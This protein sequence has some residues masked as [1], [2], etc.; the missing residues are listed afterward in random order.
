MNC[1]AN[2]STWWGGGSGWTSGGGGGWGGTK[3]GP[4]K[5]RCGDG[6]LQSRHGEECDDGN[7]KDDDGCSD[8]CRLE[9]WTEDD[10]DTTEDKFESGIIKAI[11]KLKDAC[12]Y[13]DLVYENIFFRDVYWSPYRSAISVLKSAC[14]INGYGYGKRS[15]A[16]FHADAAVGIGE[17]IKVVSK[18]YALEEGVMFDETETHLGRLPYADMKANARYTTYVIY[19]YTHGLLDGI[20]VNKLWS[21]YLKAFTPISPDMLQQLLYNAGIKEDYRD[22][23][24]WW[25][26]VSRDRFAMIVTDAFSDKLIDYKYMNGNNIT[27][28]DMILVN[29]KWKSESAQKSYIRTLIS[30]LQE[31]DAEEMAKTYGIDLE[32]LLLFLRKITPY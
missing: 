28:Y 27:I 23:M 20:G 5:W 7:Y 15:S 17:A 32:W 25:K 13:D 22:E 19:A 21:T 1:I 3:W 6:I 16:D 8:T 29:L 31:Q 14:I 2:Y 4:L 9:D 11:R 26:Y 18:I 24:G 30:H 10:D 12:V